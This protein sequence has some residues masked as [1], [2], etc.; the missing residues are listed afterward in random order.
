MRNK[1]RVLM[2]MNRSTRKNKN[3]SLRKLAE[4]FQTLSRKI[5][6]FS[7]QGLL[8]SHFLEEVSKVIIH[9]SGSDS[10]ELWLKDRDKYFRCRANRHLKASSVFEITPSAEIGKGE[11]VPGP[12]DD[13]NL[14]ALCRDIILDQADLS[15]PGFKKSGSYW[16]D[17][18]KKPPSL[19]LK[20]NKKFYL[21]GLNSKGVHPSLG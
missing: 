5:L 7:N 8:I 3:A 21:H 20:R 17:S 4:G 19:H 13:P 14:F 12:D 16:L 18:T 11:M 2:G 6:H 15:Q 10:I 9:F 1:C